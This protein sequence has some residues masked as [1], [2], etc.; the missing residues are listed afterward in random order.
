MDSADTTARR[1][2]STPV[3]SRREPSPYFRFSQAVRGRVYDKLSAI[4]Q[5][6]GCVGYH[7]TN[8]IMI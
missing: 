8:H 3:P 4:G 6:A 7:V 2:P 1:P 5:G